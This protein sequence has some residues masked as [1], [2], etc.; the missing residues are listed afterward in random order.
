[1][2]EIHEYDTGVVCEKRGYTSV[3]SQ[4]INYVS[5]KQLKKLARIKSKLDKLKAQAKKK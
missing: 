1:M 2:Q 5:K 3:C 4:C